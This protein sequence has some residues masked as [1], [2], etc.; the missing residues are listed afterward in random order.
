MRASC[1][2]TRL[3]T[4]NCV[5]GPTRGSSA[6][7]LWRTLRWRKSRS[8]RT[9]CTWF[10]SPNTATNINTPNFRDRWRYPSS[11]TWWILIIKL[12]ATILIITGIP[13]EIWVFKANQTIINYKVP[14]RIN[15]TRIMVRTNSQFTS[16]LKVTRTANLSNL[17]PQTATN[18]PSFLPPPRNLLSYPV[19]WTVPNLSQ[20]NQFC[21]KEWIYIAS[22]LGVSRI[23]CKIS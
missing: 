20:P 22:N 9:R 3:S 13:L 11:T 14:L 21:R 2:K 15:K 8:T 18:K 17:C 16:R 5:R 19:L 6:T 1:N 10:L 4:T 23:S 12:E 7:C